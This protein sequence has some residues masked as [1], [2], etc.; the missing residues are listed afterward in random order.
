MKVKSLIGI[1][2]FMTC[3]VC[4]AVFA[5][6][7][8]PKAELFGGL[9]IMSFEDPDCAIHPKGSMPGWGASVAVNID[10]NFAIKADFSGVYRSVSDR[11]GNKIDGSAVKQHNIL[12]GM[13]YTKR[14]ND[15]NVFGEALGG[16]VTVKFYSYALAFI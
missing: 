15:I 13:Q 7:E 10:P 1:G 5:Q 3:V 11:S 16:L 4:P 14:F 12:G 8:V 9:S 2:C 6:E